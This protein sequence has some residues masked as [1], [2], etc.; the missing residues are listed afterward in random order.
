M[1]TGQRRQY[2]G[3]VE[4]IWELDCGQNVCII[5]FWCQW[6]KP[7]AVAVD[8]YG[9]TTVDLKYRLQRRSVGSSNRCCKVACYLYPE[10]PR[11]HV[12]VSGKQRIMGADGV[13]SP[14]QY[15]Y[16]ELQLFTDHPKKIKAVEDRLNKTK[17]MLWACP[18]GEKRTVKALAPK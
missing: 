4:E 16:E 18:D 1:S 11:R 7:S 13:Q 3:Q 6:V 9:L 5:A 12:V 8:S 14:E 17:I 15:N 2:Y 10:D